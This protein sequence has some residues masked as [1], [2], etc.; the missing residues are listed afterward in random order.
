MPSTGATS[1]TWPVS[2]RVKPPRVTTAPFF[3][4]SRLPVFPSSKPL[5]PSAGI[6]Q[7]RLISSRF[8]TPSSSAVE[9]LKQSGFATLDTF[10]RLMDNTSLQDIAREK[11]VWIDEAGFLSIRQMQW[12]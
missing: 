2:L 5:S 9:I 7:K 6:G 3:I 12:V 10:Q 8:R 1:T 4:G 11:I